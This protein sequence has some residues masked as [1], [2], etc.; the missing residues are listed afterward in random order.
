MEEK[1]TSFGREHLGASSIPLPDNCMLGGRTVL[2]QVGGGGP[3]RA[4]PGER[5]TGSAEATAATE[6]EAK[7]NDTETGFVTAAD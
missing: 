5:D 7:P 1:P 2:D 3:Q 4:C 6:R